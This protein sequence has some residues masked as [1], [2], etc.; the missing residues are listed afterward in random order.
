MEYDQFVD[1][2]TD[3][4]GL[5]RDEAEKLTEATLRVLATVR[6]AV[7]PEQFDDMMNRLDE[8]LDVVDMPG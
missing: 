3:E 6:S 8:D 2:L 7:T 1:A 4:G 5:P